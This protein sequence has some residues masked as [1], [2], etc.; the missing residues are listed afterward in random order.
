MSKIVLRNVQLI[1]WYGF[2]NTVVTVAENLTLI[3]G[4]NECGKSTILDAIKY[5]YTGDTQF[6]KATSGY[7]TGV[8][9][10]NLISYTRCLVDASAGVYA[11]PA[12]KIPVV[13]THIALEYYDQIN[14]KSFV[15]GVIIETAVT[16]IRGTYWYAME[17]KR[18]SDISYVYED[19][20]ALKPYDASGFQKRYNVKLRKKQDGVALFMQ[21]V[22]LKLP[23]QE[24]FRYQ[25][26]LR[27]IMAYNPAAKIQEFIRESVLEEHDVNFEKLKDAKKNIEQINSRLE[28]IEEEIGD[29]D[30]ILKDYAEYDERVMQLKVDDIKLKYRNMLSWKEKRCM[31]EEMI[32]KNSIEVEAQI[33][34]IKELST[35]IDAL[36]RYYME[37]KAALRELNVSKAIDNSRQQITAFEKQ[38][39]KRKSEREE[40][41]QFRKRLLHV[42]EELNKMECEVSHFETLGKLTAVDLSNS[43]KQE[44][45]DALRA[46]IRKKRDS[47]VRN[48][49]YLDRELKEVQLER[50]EQSKIVENCDRNKADY[51]HVQEQTQ[52]IREIN[53]ELKKQ[54]IDEEA[55]MA[56]EYVSELKDEAWRDAIE[57]FLGVHRYAILVSPQ[58]FDVANQVMDRSGHHYVELVNTKRLAERKIKCEEDSVYHYLQIQ[59]ETA[60]KYFQ[61]WLGAI[62][63]VELDEVAKYD[64]AMSKEGKLGRN[65]AVTYINTKKIKSYCLGGAAIELNRKRAAKKLD[66]LEKREKEILSS[67]HTMQN[68]DV[69]LQSSLDYFKDYNLEANREC[70]HLNAELE[71]EKVRYRELLE[72][73]KN[74][75]EFMALSQRVT[76]LEKQLRNKTREKDEESKKR[77]RLEAEIEQKKK[78][79]VMYQA[80]E[81]EEQKH[82]EEE[83][84]L[85]RSAAEQAITEYDRYLA[86]ENKKGGIMQL[87]EKEQMEKRV[88]SF[89]A[90]INGQQQAYNNRKQEEERLPIGL[91]YEK[92]YHQRRGK[93]WIDDLQNLQQKLKEQTMRYESIFK[94]EFV[95]NIYETARAARKDIAQINKELRK[96]K[97][98]TCYQFDVKF[99]NDNSD[100]AKILRYAEYL[101]QTGN[102]ADGQIALTKLMGYEDD[103]VERREREIKDIINRI[104]EKN[105]LAEIQK[106][107]DYRNYMSYEIIINNEEVKDGKLSKQVGYNSGAGTQIPYTLILSA[108]LSMLYNVRVNSVRL[109]FIDEPFEKM[110]DHNIKLMLDFFKNQDFQVIFC[111]PPNKLESIGS[112]CGVII[113]VLKNA[114]DDMLIGKVKF[115]DTVNG[116]N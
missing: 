24:V 44:A 55:R 12:E 93:I 53:K 76:D 32:R 5:A 39:E 43:E 87:S 70:E 38:L 16:D 98:A 49:A 107:A 8:G 112:E 72:A 56:C 111:A 78:D 106:F 75:A 110:S 82:L 4:E 71:A 73:Q 95:L 48:R 116:A 18:L 31:A 25:R 85:N 83:Q 97:F 23:Y 89:A 94:R 10:R 15:L 22:G 6:N 114:N 30:A 108:A 42:A 115:H 91:E 2:T 27:N 90:N 50:S 102:L 113:P 67:R 61:F 13:Y 41:E 54:G 3:S 81:A 45:I 19:G 62:H 52:L 79:S 68:Q 28:L 47:I 59:N 34:T 37:A 29:L 9:K 36:D 1:N 40:L 86:G 92:S 109:I 74:N 77:Y 46:E 20:S 105:D 88:S 100:Y 101:Q 104:I 11:R 66:Q 7:N 21:M 65:M 26:K 60:A 57:A 14:E 69:F 96:L 58:A 84:K 99:L 64:N 17:D 33:K 63:A 35:E 80:K 51:S 103:E